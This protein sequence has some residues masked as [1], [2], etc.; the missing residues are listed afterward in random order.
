MNDEA[1]NTAVATFRGV[2]DN[3]A[4]DD[5]TIQQAW[6]TFR[7]EYG[8]RF[9]AKALPHP[10]AQQNLQPFSLWAADNLE[11][12]IIE[13]VLRVVFAEDLADCD[14]ISLMRSTASKANTTMWHILLYFG[15]SV[16]SS[17]LLGHV[18]KRVHVFERDSVTGIWAFPDMYRKML[19]AAAQRLKTTIDSTA[20]PCPAGG[21]IFTKPDL[22]ALAP[23]NPEFYKTLQQKS[24]ASGGNVIQR[25][26]STAN[27][28]S[29]I[30]NPETIAAPPENLEKSKGLQKKPKSHSMIKVQT[31]EPQLVSSQHPVK[32]EAEEVATAIE[33][34]KLVPSKR[35]IKEEVGQVAAAT[36]TRGKRAK[37]GMSRSALLQHENDWDDDT[38]R[39]I[40]NCLV[41]MCPNKWTVIDGMRDQTT[42][43]L[44][45]PRGKDGQK[46]FLLVPLKSGDEHHEHRVLAIVNLK[47]LSD[48]KK[49][50]IQY[51]DSAGT[52]YEDAA[53]EYKPAVKLAR[54]LTNILPGL[55]LDQTEWETKHCSCPKLVSEKDS[56]LAVSLAAIYAVS[57]RPLPENWDWQSMRHIV[58]GAFFPGDSSV[59]VGIRQ[60]RRRLIRKL[61]RQGNMPGD[62]LTYRG[63]Q[64]SPE[65]IEE[66]TTATRNPVERIEWREENSR[67]M[68][69]TIHEGYNVFQALQEQ[70]D[71]GQ[72]SFRAQLDKYAYIQSDLRCKL[73]IG[74]QDSPIK[75]EDDEHTE[76]SFNRA[77]LQ[78]ATKEHALYHGYLKGLEAADKYVQIAS[79]ILE[80]WRR[81]VYAAIEERDESVPVKSIE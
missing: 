40:L 45:P 10:A 52:Q 54:L 67:K 77:T 80:D 25:E 11:A 44:L 55:N 8:E 5:H 30:N 1:W 66:L 46:A 78:Q 37:K 6:N 7:Q 21:R 36:D 70:V 51:Y 47:P 74:S 39:H 81:L 43:P 19:R 2:V 15:V 3:K 4:A 63:R 9:Q 34:I 53:A 57:G 59:L 49:N 42:S 24:A 14:H 64:A 28:A 29:E 38:I 71:L 73:G 72:A 58:L 12:A 65:E 31:N 79:Q 33:E 13:R 61:I 23:A 50:T 60:Y 26:E 76:E 68:F 75:V 69:T 62:F 41:S 48:S 20:I 32:K 27:M 17:H 22:A 18:R 56:G 16:F 35:P